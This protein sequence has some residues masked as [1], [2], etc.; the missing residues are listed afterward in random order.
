MAHPFSARAVLPSVY[1]PLAAPGGLARYHWDRGAVIA[2]HQHL[3]AHAARCCGTGMFGPRHRLRH[4]MMVRRQIAHR[5]GI[6]GVAGQE[7]R[8]AAATAEVLG[9]FRTAAT[10][11]LHPR[12]AAKA[13]EGRR[14]IPDGADVRLTQIG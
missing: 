10:G 12:L 11:L 9:S 8:L 13:V 7:V 2:K 1:A 5:V 6:V 14:V 4:P 3:L